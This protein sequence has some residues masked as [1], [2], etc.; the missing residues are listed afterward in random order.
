MA[1]AASRLAGVFPGST[2][3]IMRR[4]KEKTPNHRPTVL[5]GPS[6]LSVFAMS[7]FHLWVIDPGL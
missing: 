3:K 2:G 7:F 1:T 6:F 5:A 4:R